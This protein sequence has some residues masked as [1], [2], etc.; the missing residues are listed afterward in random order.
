MKDKCQ[1]MEISD[2]TLFGF[3]ATLEVHIML[4]MLKT[5]N[6][7]TVKETYL[8]STIFQ[9]Y[10]GSQFNWRRKPEY[11]EKTTDLPQVTDKLIT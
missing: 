2:V 8:W 6:L 1:V 11:P 4:H 3:S 5:Q 9:L 10:R 7:S